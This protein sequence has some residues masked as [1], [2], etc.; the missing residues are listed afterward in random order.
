MAGHL[1]PLKVVGLGL[2][3][4]LS[5]VEMTVDEM[6]YWK[7]AYLEVNTVEGLA[8]SMVESLDAVWVEML[9]EM[10]AEMKAVQKVAYVVAGMV[11][12]LAQITAEWKVAVT[13]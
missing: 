7:A 4:V 5:P 10:L 8:G 3:K 1:A 11:E 2:S 13:V 9:V 6:E 12:L